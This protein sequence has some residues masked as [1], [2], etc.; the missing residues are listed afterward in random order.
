MVE[1][2]SVFDLSKAPQPVQTLA[3]T[4]TCVWQKGHCFKIT[5]R[6]RLGKLLSLSTIEVNVALIYQHNNWLRENM[7]SKLVLIA[8]LL[9]LFILT[10]CNDSE[11]AQPKT[12]ADKEWKGLTGTK[13]VEFTA[14][15][16][17]GPTPYEKGMQR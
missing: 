14:P 5:P 15:S 9:P 3:P 13:R 6:I 7:K 8:A 10:A 17:N 12:K 4:G 2:A 11:D 1:L 16:G